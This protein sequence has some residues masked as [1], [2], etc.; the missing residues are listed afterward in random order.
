M[1]ETG[2]FCTREVP[3]QGTKYVNISTPSDGLYLVH[4]LSPALNSSTWVILFTETYWLITAKFGQRLK[5][6]NVWLWGVVF[7]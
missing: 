3:Q 4:L 6:L 5:Q 2:C 1:E 7:Y